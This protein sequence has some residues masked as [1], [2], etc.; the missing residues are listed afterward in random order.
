MLEVWNTV[1][2]FNLHIGAGRSTQ[3]AASLQVA[4]AG[5]TQMGA[6]KV[7]SNQIHKTLEY[8]LTKRGI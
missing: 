7:Q 6:P 1:L 8:I 3:I 4:D 5:E 2:R